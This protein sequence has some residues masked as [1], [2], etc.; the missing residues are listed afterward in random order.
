MSVYF[1]PIL[2]VCVVGIIAGIMLTVAAR[3]MYVPVD[4]RV[5]ACLDA[6]P[7]ANCGGCGFAGCSDYAG[8][9]VDGAEITLCPVGGA[10]VAAKLGAIMG[11]EATGGDG[12]YAVVRCGGYDNKT[13][14]IL[15]YKGVASCSA[16]KSLYGGAGVCRY[17]CLGLGDCVRACKFNAIGVVNGVAWVDREN[18]TGCGACA[19]ACPNNLIA[20]VPKKSLVYVACSSAEKGAVTKKEC[21]A[22][23]IGCKKCEKT[24]KF[25]AIRIIDNHAVIDADK[26]KNCGLCARECPTG[27]ILK[28]PKPK[29]AAPANAAKNADAAAKSA[30][31]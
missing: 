18:C 19:K 14:K 22:G 5:D 3:I 12:Q 25:E 16:N 15:E 27:A 23:C 26:C 24:C 20:M 9:I 4:E 1:I 11:I 28:L 21:E 10:D 7:G 6:L 29:K 31:V 30:A 2:L 8:A 13:G 17:G